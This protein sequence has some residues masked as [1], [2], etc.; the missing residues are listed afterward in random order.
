M[1]VRRDKRAR[2]LAQRFSVALGLELD[3]VVDGWL[4]YRTDDDEWDDPGVLPSVIAFE[5]RGLTDQDHDDWFEDIEI[6]VGDS[7]VWPHLQALTAIT[8]RGGL[9]W[10]SVSVDGGDYIPAEQDLG[11]WQ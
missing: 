7:A 4:I 10:G 11:D 5:H 8:P 3:D 2:D 1:T 9:G 6:A